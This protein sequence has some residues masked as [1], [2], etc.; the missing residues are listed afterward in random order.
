MKIDTLERT[1]LI[2]LGV[3]IGV[4][5]IFLVRIALLLQQLGN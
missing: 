5:T 1:V 4:L 2:I 3:F